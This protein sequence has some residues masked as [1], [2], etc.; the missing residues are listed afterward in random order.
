MKTM[1]LGL[2]VALPAFV[3]AAAV[4]S[5][6]ADLTATITLSDG[7][8]NTNGGEFMAAYA[9]LPFV[10]VGLPDAP[11]GQ[12]ETFCIETNET[13]SF[14]A[15]YYADVATAADHGGPDNGPNPL[16]PLAAYLYAEFIMGQLAGY[17]Y[18]VSG[19]PAARAASAD[20]LQ[21][22]VWFIQ[23]QEAKTWNDGD[24]SLM[25]QFYQNASAN[26][27]N[28]IGDVRVLVLFDDAAA[29]TPRQ[30][31]LVLTPEPASLLLGGLGPIVLAW[32][33]RRA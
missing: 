17:T 20:A 14:G 2:W 18:D 7:Y 27:T 3:L 12:F 25:D 33:R 28:D 9:D 22:V 32:A 6:N 26:A 15:T 5:A 13:I 24:G 10:P 29:T 16:S 1:R 8:G 4:S 19:G 31:Q 21:H 11:P 30:D 23:N